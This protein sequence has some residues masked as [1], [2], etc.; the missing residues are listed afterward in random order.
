MS[1]WLYKPILHIV[2][3]DFFSVNK[4]LGAKGYS[5]SSFLFV[6]L[7]LMQAFMGFYVSTST[8]RLKYLKYTLINLYL[9]S[10]LG[11][12]DAYC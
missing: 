6:L 11:S 1:W 2:T 7:Y 12:A 9:E 4:L 10:F 8:N 5:F 3:E